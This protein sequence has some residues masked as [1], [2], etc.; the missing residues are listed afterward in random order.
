M[1]GLLLFV[2]VYFGRIVFNAKRAVRFRAI[3][4]VTSDLHSFI[5]ANLVAI[6]VLI[7]TGAD[8][9]ATIVWFYLVLGDLVAEAKKPNAEPAMVIEA[10]EIEPRLIARP[11]PVVS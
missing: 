9:N 4:P 8:L 1:P 2:I 6:V 5:F 11:R 3:D 7:Y 10:Q